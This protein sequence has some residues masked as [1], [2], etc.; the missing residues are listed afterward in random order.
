MKKYR[1]GKINAAKWLSE[2]IFYYFKKESLFLDEFKEHIQNQKKELSEL[3]DGEF[4]QGLYDE[5]N[6]IEDILDK[7]AK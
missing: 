7:Y 4:K 5:L 3:K 6:I 2:L 1:K